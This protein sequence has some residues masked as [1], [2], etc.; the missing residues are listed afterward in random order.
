MKIIRLFFGVLCSLIMSGL[1]YSCTTEKLKE[2]DLLDSPVDSPVDT[3][4]DSENGNAKPRPA[5]VIKPV[6][7]DL[8]GVTGIVVAAKGDAPLTRAGENMA[9]V[10]NSLYS[11]D[12]EG[13]IKLMIFYYEVVA[14]EIP[15]VDD[16][17]G[18]SDSS[19][20]NDGADKPEDTEEETEDYAAQIQREMSL[21]VQAIPTHITDLG[22]YILFSECHYSVDESLLSEDAKAVIQEYIERNSAKDFLIRKS[23]G[24]L[25]DV[26][27][28]IKIVKDKE[29]KVLDGFYCIWD[30][31]DVLFVG[32]GDPLPDESYTG[33]WTT[34]QKPPYI[35]ELFVLGHDAVY[36][37]EDRGD[38]LDFIPMTNK[39]RNTESF[40]M[41]S[42]GHIYL[43]SA[44]NEMQ[45]F[46]NEWYLDNYHDYCMVQSEEPYYSVETYSPEKKFNIIDLKFGGEEDWGFYKMIGCVSSSIKKIETIKQ[47][48]SV[49]SLTWECCWYNY[50]GQWHRNDYKTN[51]EC[52][53]CDV[54][55]DG[56]LKRRTNLEL[57][58]DIQKIKCVGPYTYSVITSEKAYTVSLSFSST[59]WS[60]KQVAA[61]LTM[62]NPDN[63]DF[64]YNPEDDVFCGVK[65]EGNTVVIKKYTDLGELVVERTVELDIPVNL[66]KPE[67]TFG[68]R[69]N[70]LYLDITA[71]TD[72]GGYYS[73]SFNLE[74]GEG[75]S[76]IEVPPIPG[77]VTYFKI[78]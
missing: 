40:A 76:S 56:Q 1:F 37:V 26:T 45:R 67:T 35:D 16:N 14:Q 6:G 23:D 75:D 36:R 34:A 64:S 55:E 22:K 19:S 57:P 39:L 43:F 29:G 18:E 31:N 38:A 66:I 77:I 12:E 2:D 46:Q 69:D 7:I 58:S 13:N 72:D 9:G 33:S 10:Q 71:R 63:Y 65:L 59:R 68:V 49:L 48:V 62:L 30:L 20:E 61:D 70:V 44:S 73:S 32:S 17:S 47:R 15:E 28:F 53:I 11:V 21:A 54:L 4:S 8:T 42:N 52:L 74:T 5:L 25:Y 3:P 50:Y 78:N 60:S 27:G 24:G 41:D 51:D